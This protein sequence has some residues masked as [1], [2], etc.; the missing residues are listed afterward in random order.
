MN[1]L[2]GGRQGKRYFKVTACSLEHTKIQLI[3]NKI[4]NITK[5]AEVPEPYIF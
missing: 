5:L 2:D 1:G 4:G 3:D